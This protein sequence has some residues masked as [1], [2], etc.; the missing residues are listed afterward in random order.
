MPVFLQVHGTLYLDPY[1]QVKTV[2]P[3]VSFT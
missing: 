1:E 2:S 3:L